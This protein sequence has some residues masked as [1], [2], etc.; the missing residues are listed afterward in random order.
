MAS[1]NTQKIPSKLTWGDHTAG[2]NYLSKADK[3]YLL[4]DRFKGDYFSTLYVDEDRLKKP[5]GDG[6][7]FMACLY[8]NNT[9]RFLGL[10]QAEK[11]GSALDQAFFMDDD[12]EVIYWTGFS[13]T[14]RK[15]FKAGNVQ[16]G[17]E[18]WI[19]Q[20]YMKC[21]KWRKGIFFMLRN[22]TTRRSWL[23]RGI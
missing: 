19:N 6:R 2:L 16:I 21:S 12:T 9:V 4:G 7:L 15:N 22:H 8:R 17:T 3:K 11:F 10:L 5:S 20:S 1:E 14:M 18:F 13:N 23:E